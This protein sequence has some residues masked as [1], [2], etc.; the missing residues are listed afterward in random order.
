MGRKDRDV[1]PLYLTAN[2]GAL[3]QACSKEQGWAGDRPSNMNWWFTCQQFAQV[4]AQQSRS[5]ENSSLAQNSTEY[6]DEP[7]ASHLKK[8]EKKVCYSKIIDL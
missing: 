3:P 6:D 1:R 7:A 4:S 8:K 2:G 5:S